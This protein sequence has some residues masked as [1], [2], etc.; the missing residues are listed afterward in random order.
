MKIAI[1]LNESAGLA[2]SVSRVFARCMY[3]M[4]IDSETKEFTIEENG[5]THEASGAG[6][7]AA[8]YLI[9]QGV[10][11]VISGDIGPKA[12]SVLAAE[13]IKKYRVQGKT[14]GEALESYLNGELE[15][16]YSSTNQMYTGKRQDDK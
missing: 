6:I 15:S 5:A 3:I 10:G 9:K 8:Q 2:S 1:T 14:A 7:K 4:F 16:L 12:A 13:G 11:A